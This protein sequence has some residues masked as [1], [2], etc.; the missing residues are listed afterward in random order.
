MNANGVTLSACRYIRFH[1]TDSSAKC[2]KRMD[3]R[4]F[5]DRK[6]SARHVTEMD[7]QR[8]AQGE[9]LS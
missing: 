5:D 9:W 3:G 7:F 8:A 1:D 2:K 6:I 4:M